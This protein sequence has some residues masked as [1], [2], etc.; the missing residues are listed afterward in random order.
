MAPDRGWMSG[1]VEA[2]SFRGVVPGRLGMV[3]WIAAQPCTYGQH[4]L[5]GGK[6]K[7]ERRILR[8]KRKKG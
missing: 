3:H 8:N 6:Q 2:V 4:K 5:D 1:E 7:G